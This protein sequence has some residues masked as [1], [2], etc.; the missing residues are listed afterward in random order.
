MRLGIDLDGVVANFNKGWIDRY[1]S[2]FGTELHN[3]SVVSWDGIVQETHFRS[4]GDF[5]HWARD[6]ADGSIFRHLDTFAW[7]SDVRLPTR[8]V[9]IIEDKWAV[10][11]EIYLDDAP[12]IL[13]GLRT[14]RPD[15]T[16]CRFVRPWNDPLPD[17][18]DVADWQQFQDVVARLE[19]Q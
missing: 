14:H 2:E 5:W 13:K 7:I 11:C 4:M 8:E 1:N 16:T 6:L 3:E 9:H 18:V 15:A 12:H 17:V 10:P 19:H